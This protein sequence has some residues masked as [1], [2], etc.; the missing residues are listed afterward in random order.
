MKIS[1]IEDAGYKPTWDI[2]VIPQHSYLLSNGI[3]SHNTL[4]ILA[5]CSSSIEPLFGKQFTKTVLNGVILDL[6][7]KYKNINDELLVT[8]FEIPVEKHIEM[9]SSFQMY[10][11][12]AV[13]KTINL[14]SKA[15]E[16][17]VKKAFLKAW[18]LK[19]KGITVY[20]EGSR[21]GPVEITTE[22]YLSECSSGKCSI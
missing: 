4:S 8:A 16:E 15:T 22:G 18:E 2:E 13:S 21:Q 20:R 12:N 10:T 14:Q 5:D 19:C 11:D 9:Q 1:K 3:V 17:D 6:G 7:A